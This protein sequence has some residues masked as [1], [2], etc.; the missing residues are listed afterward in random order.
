MT[1]RRTVIALSSSPRR[2]GNSRLLAEAVLEGA[3]E[4]GHQVRC[5]HL[6]DHVQFFLRNCREC[7]RSDGSC[8]IEDG[9]RDLFLNGILPAD[10]LVLATPIWWYGMSA[11]LKNVLDRMF[12]YYAASYPDHAVVHQRLMGKRLALVLSA[13]ETNLSARLGVVHQVQEI[14][15]YLHYTFAGVVTGIGNA[16][17]EVRNDPNQPLVHARELGRRLFDIRETDYRMDVERPGK[18]WSGPSSPY[19]SF[20]R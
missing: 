15:R 9:Y 12:C 6:A 13:E 8:S 14:C 20:W 18:V 1:E 11:T 5:V 3:A 19:P 4:A 16:T 2:A 10:A 7:R 17:G